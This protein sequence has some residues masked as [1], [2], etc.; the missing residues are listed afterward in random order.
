[1]N[2]WM[3][4]Q[5]WESF[6]SLP[7]YQELLKNTFIYITKYSIIKMPY[8]YYS[9][10][11]MVYI[12]VWYYHLSISFL[13]ACL[14]FFWTCTYLNILYCV[15][16]WQRQLFGIEAPA[17]TKLIGWR[18]H[19]NSYTLQGRR[20]VRSCFSLLKNCSLLLRACQIVDLIKDKRNML[21]SPLSQCVIFFLPLIPFSS[22]F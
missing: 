18:K 19:F 3:I 12:K 9:F 4:E 8:A 16:L 14:M 15:F 1:M 2:E 20:N 21:T 6:W 22:L 11:T 13:F 10:S 5:T 17:Q 7:L